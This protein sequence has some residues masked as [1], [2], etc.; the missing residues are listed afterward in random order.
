M[1]WVVNATPW[2]SFFWERDSVPIV[3]EAELAPGLVWA[4]VGNLASAG[5]QSVNCLQQVALLTVLSQPS[6]L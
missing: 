2:V 3:Q 4:G 1:E 5:I 6:T